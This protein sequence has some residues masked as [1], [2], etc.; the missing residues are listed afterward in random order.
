MKKLTTEKFINESIKIHGDKNDYSMINYIT[1]KIKVKIICKKHGI[2]EKYPPVHLKGHGCPICKQSKGEKQ[3]RQILENKNINYEVD[4]KFTNCKNIHV[5]PF[6]F[7]L[8]T[9][10]ICIEFDGIQHFQL[11]EFF[12]NQK[13]FENIQKRDKIK[14]YFCKNNNIELIRIKYNENIESKLIHII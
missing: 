3:I 14:T 8:P 11:N 7:Y 6:D 4:K 1:N 5:L 9:Y 13:E 10:N 2:F 12:T